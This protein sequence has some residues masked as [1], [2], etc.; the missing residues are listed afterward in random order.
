MGIFTKIIT[1]FILWMVSTGVTYVMFIMG[2]K[3]FPGNSGMISFSIIANL[4]LNLLFMRVLHGKL[5]VRAHLRPSVFTMA[6]FM[7]SWVILLWIFIYQPLKVDTNTQEKRLEGVQWL[8]GPGIDR[9]AYLEFIPDSLVTDTPLIYLHPGPGAFA[10]ENNVLREFFDS[11]SS[12]G[13]R[14]IIYDRPGSGLSSRND[15]PAVYSKEYQLTHLDAI[16]EQLA[17]KPV[18]LIGESYGA[19]LAARYAS[20]H[21]D[22]VAGLSLVSPGPLYNDPWNQQDVSLYS[23][24]PLEDKKQVNRMRTK[25][26]IITAYLIS[27]RD[28]ETAVEFLPHVE[29][30][31]YFS[32]LF[33]KLS[34][35]G[36]CD[37][38]SRNYPAGSCGFWSSIFTDRNERGDTLSIDPVP[39]L[40][41]EIIRG[42]CDYFSAQVVAPYLLA[43]PSAKSIS[44]PEAGHFIINEK[45]WINLPF[46][47]N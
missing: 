28:A 21:P 11:L 46:V 29:A 19:A 25:L 14:G 44:I 33:K 36:Y 43:F 37:S 38:T 12:L 23:R 24:L 35:G 9:M 1:L 20:A 2:A 5:N 26:R 34:P 45:A 42:E 7:L 15:N 3:W 40:E 16:V 18:W 30:D 31:A 22:K 17:G 4:L 13:I 47:K 10:L 39:D 27:Q 6:G 41:V 32:Q 8:E